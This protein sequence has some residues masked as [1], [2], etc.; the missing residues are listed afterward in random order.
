ML[1]DKVAVVGAGTMGSGIAMACA[2]AGL[3]VLLTDATNEALAAGDGNIRRNYD[4][5]IARGRLTPESV[6]ERRA[7]IHLVPAAAFPAR[8][9]AAE[10]SSR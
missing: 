3:E 8:I 7:R 4:I 2:N 1:P 9:A 5:T 10:I 6:A